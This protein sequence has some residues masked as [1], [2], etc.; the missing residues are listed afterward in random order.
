MNCEEPKLKVAV[1]VG[2]YGC[3]HAHHVQIFQMK[4]KYHLPISSHASSIDVNILF[5]S[6]FPNPI[7]SSM[8]LHLFTHHDRPHPSFKFPV[9][10]FFFFSEKVFI[11]IN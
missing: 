6:L 2:G 8:Q 5:F 11:L 7:I 10:V 4:K 1:K 3:P 9:F